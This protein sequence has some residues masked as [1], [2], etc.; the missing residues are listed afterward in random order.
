LVH[1]CLAQ[2]CGELVTTRSALWRLAE[3]R[4]DSPLDTRT[5]CDRHVASIA[6][7]SASPS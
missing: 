4:H 3:T 2:S 1:E 6:M 7:I 5:C